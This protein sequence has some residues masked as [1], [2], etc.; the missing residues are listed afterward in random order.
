MPKYFLGYIKSNFEYLAPML[1]YPCI[2]WFCEFVPLAF[3]NHARE[4]P[5]QDVPLAETL[6]PHPKSCKG[7]EHTEWGGKECNQSQGGQK[8]L[9]LV[10]DQF[11]KHSRAMKDARQVPQQDAEVAQWKSDAVLSFYHFKV[12]EFSRAQRAMFL[13]CV[14]WNLLLY[15]LPCQKC[16]VSSRNSLC[17]AF[18]NISSPCLDTLVRSFYQSN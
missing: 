6:Q 16:L 8:H 9:G 2:F 10:Q 13:P 17:L 1:I 14:P 4:G 11:K 5:L 12:Y 15:W 3:T 7:D 18:G